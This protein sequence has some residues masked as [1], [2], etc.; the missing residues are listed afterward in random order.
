[1]PLELELQSIPLDSFLEALVA[2]T[3]HDLTVIAKP[4]VES[5]P[6]LEQDSAAIAKA[7]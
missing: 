6:V 4:A 7:G 1:M 2:L 5:E 3:P